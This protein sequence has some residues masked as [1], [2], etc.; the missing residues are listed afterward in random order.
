MACSPLR[1]HRNIKPLVFGFILL[2]GVVV[3][4]LEMMGILRTERNTILEE[5]SS[6]ASVSGVAVMDAEVDVRKKK[7]KSLRKSVCTLRQTISSLS[8]CVFQ[9][10]R[11]RPPDSP[12]NLAKNFTSQ[13]WKSKNAGRAN[14]HVFGDWCGT[15]VASLRKNIHYPLYPH[16]K[17]AVQKLAISPQLTNYGIRIFGYL[18]PYTDGEFVFAVSS[19]DNSELWLSPDDSPLHVKLF[20]WVGK[21]GAEWTALGE[22]TKFVSQTSRPVWLSAQKRYFFEVIHKQDDKGT[23]HVEVAWK[24]LNNS[25]GFTVIESSHISL[26]VDES[27]LLLS[28]VDHIPQTTASH[29]YTPTNKNSDTIDM[30]KEDPRDT[31]YKV[32]L[33]NSIFLRGV[34]PD[35]LY[36]PT[37]TI[38]GQK[39]QRYQGLQHVHM[40]FVYPNDYTRLTHLENQDSCF[41]SAKPSLIRDPAET[42]EKYFDFKWS[43]TVQVKNFDLQEHRSDRIDL[44]C[45]VKGNLLLSASDSLPLAQAFMDKLNEKHPGLFTLVRVVNVV[46]RAD[47]A[48]GSRYLLELEVKDRNSQVLRLSHYIYRSVKPT[49]INHNKNS[50]SRFTQ[51]PDQPV[52]CNPVGLEWNPAATVHFILAVKNQGRWV[53]QLISEMEKLVRITGD[54]NFNVIIVDYSSTD[55]D[56]KKALQSSNLPR[57]QYLKLDGHFQRSCG[58]QA[59]VDHVKDEHSI[60]FL[61]DLHMEY[62]HSII[63]S[64]R[65]HTVEGYMAFA[66]IIMRLDCGSTSEEA[67]GFWEVNGFGLLG[68]Y[69]SDLDAVGGMNTKDYTDRWGGED[70]EL[71]DRVFQ[72]GMEVERINVKNLFHYYH[73]RQGM[74]NT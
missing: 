71:I 15:S 18:H 25:A 20:A 3:V 33:I 40:S 24:L 61:C 51:P 14:L 55:V 58:L 41:Y 7:R 23:D 38:K 27:A 44:Q 42:N 31:F 30:K 52:L 60:I 4:C 72:S 62:P 2:V 59:G 49:L 6:G 39:L 65:K 26:Y 74:W 53:H 22:F 56:V 63:D 47:G 68:I 43:H 5:S 50:S 67:R 35:C 8:V 21:T 16:T 11:D 48:H 29:K 28:N 70:W 17:T 36:K 57:Y 12:E 13:T 46:K 73:T 64:I 1:M 37:Y 32:P 45:T 19:D 10:S 34:L 69:K 66:P 9:L 54:T